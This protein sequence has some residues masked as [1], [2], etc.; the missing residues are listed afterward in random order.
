[1]RR[2]DEEEKGTVDDPLVKR[3]QFAISLRKQKRSKIIASK[4]KKLE[5]M[6]TNAFG[7]VA[8]G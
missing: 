8:S 5:I 4:R 7:S 2:D 6:R 1:M 3:E